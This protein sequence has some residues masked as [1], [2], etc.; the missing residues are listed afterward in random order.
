PEAG[1]VF[2]VVADERLAR[3]A[4]E[5]RTLALREGTEKQRPQVTLENLFGETAE[6]KSE[7]TLNLILKADVRGSLEPLR[8]E[9][10]K[11]EHKEVKLNLLYAA[12]GAVTQSDV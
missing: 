8:V 4:V 9:L 7:K 3:A 2:R 11:L 1:D 12:L 5:E 10:E 6:E